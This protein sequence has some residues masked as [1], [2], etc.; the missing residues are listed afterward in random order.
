MATGITQVG[1]VSY[2]LASSGAM[3]TGWGIDPATDNWCLADSSGVLK[4]GW[5]RVGS[6]WY[7][8]GN[9]FRM[10]TGRQ[11]VGDSW[12]WMAPGGQMATG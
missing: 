6:S 12:Y 2:L 10:L 8:M 4:S 11:Q 5:Q 1:N 3:V 7:L 9:D